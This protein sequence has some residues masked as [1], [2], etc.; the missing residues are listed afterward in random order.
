M[1]RLVHVAITKEQIEEFGLEHLTN[2]DP[3]VERK[4]KDDPNASSF[5]VLNEGRLFQIAVDALDALN[6]D[7]LKRLLENI[8]SYFDE[9]IHEQVLS[10]PD[11]Q[12]ESVRGIV[13]KKIA[14]YYLNSKEQED[15]D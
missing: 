5:K 8:D 2:P 9:E 10:D 13:H 14:D 12:P 1:P 4:L 3:E 7:D 15:D 11:H 6:P